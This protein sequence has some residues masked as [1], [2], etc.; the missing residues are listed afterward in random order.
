MAGNPSNHRLNQELV[1]LHGIVPVIV[2][3]G[4]AKI[5]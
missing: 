3:F 1:G 2:K 5:K 4:S